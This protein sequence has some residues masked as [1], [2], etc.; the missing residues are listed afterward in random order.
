MRW[1]VQ[2]GQTLLRVVQQLTQEVQQLA[3]MMAAQTG[4]QAAR[5]AQAE[6]QNRE[7]GSGP[8][9]EKSVDAKAA[10][11]LRAN[12]TGYQ[13]RLAA[14]SVPDMDTGSPNG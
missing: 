4:V 3:A 8:A 12:Q 2:Q 7:Q 13:Q 14:R 10:E 5:Q 9:P 11:A 1:Y 6:E